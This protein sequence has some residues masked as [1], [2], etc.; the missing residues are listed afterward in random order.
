[1]KKILA[2]SL[3]FAVAIMAKADDYGYMELCQNGN[4]KTIVEAKGLTITFSG[5]YLIATESSG[6]ETRLPLSGMSSMRFTSDKADGIKTV[7]AASGTVMADGG[8]L[9]LTVAE[10]TR[11][12]VASL[13]GMAIAQGNATGTAKETIACGLAPGLYIVKIGEKSLKIQVR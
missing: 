12:A 5:G 10:G 7:G 9:V 13:S 2:L 1:M 11:Y 4:D 8:S 6:T 3:L